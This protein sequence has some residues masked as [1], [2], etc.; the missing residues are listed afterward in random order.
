MNNFETTDI[1]LG[2]RGC[3]TGLII[4]SV[5]ILALLTWGIVWWF[6]SQKTVSNST[7]APTNSTDTKSVAESAKTLTANEI[8]NLT[9]QERTKAGLNPLQKNDLLTKAANNK[10][11]DMFANNYYANVSPAGKKAWEFVKEAGYDFCY[12]G[13]NLSISYFDAK[14]L[15]AAWMASPKI[16]QN[17]LNPNNKEIGVAVVEGLYQGSQNT[18]VVQF[19]GADDCVKPAP[20]PPG[21]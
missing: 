20:T 5:L 21:S 4:L 3:K 17:I 14:E 16:D 10:A 18:F 6:D 1:N 2:K 7:T 15:L 19:V 13:E 11:K 9:N 12:F 8:I